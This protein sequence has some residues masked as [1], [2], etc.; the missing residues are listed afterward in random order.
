[1][2]STRGTVVER[3]AHLLYD[4]RSIPGEVLSSIEKLKNEKMAKK[5]TWANSSKFEKCEKGHFLYNLKNT[6]FDK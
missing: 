6:F 2:T 5:T 3:L 4:A 1:M